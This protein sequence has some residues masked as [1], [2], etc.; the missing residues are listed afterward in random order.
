MPH[1]SRNKRPTHQKRQQVT[2]ND[3]WTHVTNSSNARRVFRSTAHVKKQDGAQQTDHNAQESE[4]TLGPAEAPARLTLA[5]LESQYRAHREQWITSVTWKALKADLNTYILGT[6]VVPQ[7]NEGFDQLDPESPGLAVENIVCIGL[8][9]P[10]GFLR[11]G[12]VD[13]RSVSMYQLAA[14]ECLKNQLSGSGSLSVYA[15]DPVF[16]KL[17]RD[18]LESLRMTIVEHPAAFGLITRNTLLFCPGRRGNIWTSFF[19]LIRNAFLA[20]HWK[21]PSQ[22]SFSHLWGE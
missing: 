10:S 5:E 19:L 22:T 17:D 1:S 11:G 6:R 8:G 4:P 12:W 20:G 13:R 15:Q 21:I 16:N 9:S 18:L 14:L 7:G 2:D 3:G